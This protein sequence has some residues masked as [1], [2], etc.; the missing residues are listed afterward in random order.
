MLTNTRYTPWPDLPYT[1]NF[2][3]SEVNKV[4][5]NELNQA[6][7]DAQTLAFLNLVTHLITRLTDPNPYLDPQFAVVAIVPAIEL[8]GLSSLLVHVWYHTP[9]TGSPAR[10]ATLDSLAIVADE[11]HQHGIRD[12]GATIRIGRLDVGTVRIV[13]H[14]HPLLLN[15]V[16]AP[17]IFSIAPAAS[18]L[19][20]IVTMGEPYTGPID[21]IFQALND[22]FNVLVTR[23][24][25]ATFTYVQG[26]SV[27]EG[28]QAHF[29][30]EVATFGA[31]TNVEALTA[32]AA[33]SSF[34]VEIAT[35][36]GEIHFQVYTTV[37]FYYTVAEGRIWI[38]GEDVDNQVAAPVDGNTATA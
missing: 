24:P 32:I 34:L 16:N 13:A 22:A 21:S 10:E 15:R 26:Q 4:I 1:I 20:E 8:M 5:F 25:L 19:V 36:V 14:Q 6:G 7:T 31:F 30:M 23:E 33:F 3:H 29:N 12:L 17:I 2:P 11:I 27:V 18:L 37:P 38:E 35:F 28:R 9:T